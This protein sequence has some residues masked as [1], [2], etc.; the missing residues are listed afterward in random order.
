MG[1]KFEMKNRHEKVIVLNKLSSASCRF[2]NAGQA[3]KQVGSARVKSVGSSSS[4]GGPGCCLLAA[5]HQV[6]LF[7]E[8]AEL[9]H[10][11]GPLCFARFYLFSLT[12][13]IIFRLL[14]GAYLGAIFT[15]P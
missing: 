9:R 10:L 1:Y 3:T 11:E 14:K 8:R 5:G 15:T 6:L 2:I 4:A 12:V 7:L 13:L